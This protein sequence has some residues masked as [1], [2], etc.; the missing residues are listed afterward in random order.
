MLSFDMDTLILTFPCKPGSGQVLLEAFKTA[1]KDTRAYKGCI[2][3]ITYSSATNPDD[4]V[5]IEEWDNK[6]SQATYMQWRADT[7]M[8]E[9]LQPL[10]AGPLKEEWLDRTDI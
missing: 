10:L 1:L 8:S 7:E 6:S 4:I 9:Q 3:N 5:L 2:S